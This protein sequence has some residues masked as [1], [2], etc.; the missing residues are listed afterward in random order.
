LAASLDEELLRFLTVGV[1][2][3]RAL[4]LSREFDRLLLNCVGVDGVE[5]LVTI[6]VRANTT[7]LLGDAGVISGL[8]LLVKTERPAGERAD[9][10]G[11]VR[12]HHHAM[13]RSFS[14]TVGLVMRGELAVLSDLVTPMAST[15]T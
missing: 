14:G 4:G 9:G 7:G 3:V 8:Q 5:K 10:V 12:A 15:M 13:A 11:V 1:A 6:V 2:R